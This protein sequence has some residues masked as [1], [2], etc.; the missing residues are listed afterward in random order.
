MSFFSSCK[1]LCGSDVMRAV[2]LAAYFYA[3]DEEMLNRLQ[4]L[5][6]AHLSLH[7]EK[8]EAKVTKMLEV[9]K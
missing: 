2:V 5:C 7:V 8:I 4:V 3:F 9:R 6:D 1:R